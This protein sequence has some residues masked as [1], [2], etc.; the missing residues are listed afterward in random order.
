MENRYSVH[1]EQ[2]KRFTTEELRSHFL[3]DPLFT[4]NKLTMYYSHE[5][6]VVIGG[7]TPGQSELKLDAGDFLKTDFFL[8]RREI[9]IIN[10]GQPGAVRVGDDEYVL[11]TKDFLYIGMGNQDVSFSSLNGEKAKFYFVSACAHKSYPTQKAA[12]AELTPDRLGDDAASN[13]RSL[14]KVIHQDGIKSCQLMM[15]ITMLDQNNNW[16]TMPAH[17]HDRRMEA[18]LYLDLEK[19][20]KVFHFMGQ[21]DETR[22]LVVGNEQAVLSPAWSI[23]SGAG[24]SNYSFVWAMAGENYTFTDMDLVPMDGLK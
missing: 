10:V 7:A 8:E 2:V 23:H 1:P 11:Q 3:M 20:S 21:P 14:Y 5:D 24:T 6:R 18:Y 9:G 12:L 13:V 17:V 4:E 15:G 22:H 16:N 19:D